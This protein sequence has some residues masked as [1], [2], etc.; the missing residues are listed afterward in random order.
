M[1]FDIPAHDSW[2]AASEKLRA[3]LP[4]QD[5][6]VQVHAYAGYQHAIFE[7]TQG[8]ARL[9]SHKKT[10]AVQEP[11][12][13][14]LEAI[15]SAFSEEAYTVKR[16]Q[17]SDWGKTAIWLDAIASDLIFVVASEDDPVTG[18]R[19]DL[20][21]L[22]TTLKEKRVFRVKLSHAS[23]SEEAIARPAPFEIRIL[24]LSSDLAVAVGGERFKGT[25]VLAPRMN[26][27]ADRVG[28][29][30]LAPLSPA[31]LSRRKKAVVD[32]ESRL[33]D[34]FRPYFS[35]DAH[36]VFDRAVI[37]AP[38]MDGSAVIDEV[39]KRVGVSL[40]EPGG[41]SPL[42]TTSPCRW[43]HPRFTDWLLARGDS[44]EQV[45]GLVAID[46]DRI[47]ATMAKALAEAAKTIAKRQG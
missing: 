18:R 13:P 3:A 44:E 29:A 19:F 42:E 12:E 20:A 25:P 37:Y 30:S 24:S 39:A 35:P 46:V 33:P 45:R 4:F 2:I 5:P 17:P 36:R 6:A 8:L 47:D 22:D 10:I 32:F 40:S 21:A 34:G 27:R 15:V 38:N 16:I 14:A 1:R 28:Q 43:N 7:V 31:E 11:I 9:F 41:A 23:Y 26:W